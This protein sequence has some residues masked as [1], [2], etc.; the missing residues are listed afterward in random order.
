[1]NEHIHLNWVI[2][3]PSL[4]PP[5]QRPPTLSFIEERDSNSLIRP[6][7]T[8]LPSFHPLSFQYPL[9]TIYQHSYTHCL[10]SCSSH[11]TSCFYSLHKNPLGKKTSFYSFFIATCSS[12]LF[13]KPYFLRPFTSFSSFS[14][15]HKLAIGSNVFLVY[16]RPIFQFVNFC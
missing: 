14:I 12:Y 16:A 13:V 4:R 3:Y 5:N 6:P 2:S 1:M 7:S 8:V 11:S 15:T 10:S 9:S